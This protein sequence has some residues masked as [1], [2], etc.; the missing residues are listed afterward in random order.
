MGAFAMHWDFVLLA[1]TLKFFLSSLMI[2][3]PL[4]TNLSRNTRMF[5]YP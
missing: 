2:L 3:L 4:H 5:L 1:K